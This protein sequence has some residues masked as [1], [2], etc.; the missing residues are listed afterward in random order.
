MKVLVVGASGLVGGHC[1][2]YF[3]DK[4]WDLTGTHYQYKSP[5]SVY[6][7]PLKIGDA[8]NFDIFPFEPHVIVHCAALTNVDYCETHPEESRV[9]TV[10]TARAI[11]DYCRQHRAKMVYISTDYVF[12]GS[13]GPYI[14]TD[15]V[16]P[17]NV[18]GTHKL[19]AEEIVQ[20]LDNYLICRITNVYGEEER[21]KNFIARLLVMIRNNTE[22]ELMLPVD[23][24][25]TPI[26]SGDIARMLYLLISDNHTGIFHLTS[27]DYYSRYNLALKVLSFFPEKKSVKLISC[28]TSAMNQPAKRPLSAGMLNIKFATLYPDFIF[29]TVD[30]FVLKNKNYEV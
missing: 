20:K 13:N 8:G 26:Y 2:Q 28:Q 19:E 18:Y 25:A 11:A 9:F 12:D 14:E 6:F 22:K 4:G 23:Q 15:P 3:R 17:L 21:S 24:F 29:T 5:C 30:L 10:D 16:N 7:D 1:L 27:T